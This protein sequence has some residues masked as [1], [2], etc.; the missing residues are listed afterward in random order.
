M[1]IPLG[2]QKRFAAQPLRLR[3][4]HRRQAA[5]AVVIHASLSF[6][7]ISTVFKHPAEDVV[8]LTRALKIS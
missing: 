7:C 8:K 1:A 6:H 3:K 4:K 5:A 2:P